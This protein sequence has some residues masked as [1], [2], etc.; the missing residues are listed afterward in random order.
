MI[1]IIKE[2]HKQFRDTCFKCGCEYIYELEDIDKD[3]VKCPQCGTKNAHMPYN[4][5]LPPPTPY[6]GQMAVPLDVQYG[7]PCANCSYT[8]K[9]ATG[10]VYVGDTPCTWCE[11]NPLRVTCTT[12]YTSTKGAN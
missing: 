11:H 10:Q 8:K 9:L 2:G 7:N 12:V 6:I 3:Y 4:A 1:K 5:I